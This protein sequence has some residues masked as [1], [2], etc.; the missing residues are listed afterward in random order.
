MSQIKQWQNS[1]FSL[2]TCKEKLQMK[3][4]VERPQ[5]ILPD[6]GHISKKAFEL[7]RL[8]FKVFKIS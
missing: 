2:I 3:Q 4:S 5:Q 7:L 1:V 8:F 6:Y